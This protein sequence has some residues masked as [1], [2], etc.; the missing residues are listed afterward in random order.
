MHRYVFIIALSLSL[1]IA[2]AQR[3]RDQAFKDLQDYPEESEREDPGILVH[4]MDNKAGKEKDKKTDTDLDHNN[5]RPSDTAS[6]AGSLAG[7]LSALFGLCAFLGRLY[8]RWRQIRQ[9]GDGMGRLYY[10]LLV[11]LLTI[12]HRRRNIPAIDV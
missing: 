6:L 4:R 3:S 12:F 10:D 5:G 2:F 7:G 8:Q 11:A 9:A 1:S